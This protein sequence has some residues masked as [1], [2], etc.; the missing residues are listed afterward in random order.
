VVKISLAIIL[1]Q[2][3]TRR[4]RENYFA[5]NYLICRPYLHT[6]IHTYL[7]TTWSTVLLEKLTGLQLIKKFPRFYGTRMFNTA[8]TSAHYLSLSWVS[9]IQSITPN[10]NSLRSILILSSHLRL[11]LQS[12]FF[13]PGFPHQNPEC[14]SPIHHTSYMP[15]PSHSSRFRHPNTFVGLWRIHE[16]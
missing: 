8:L 10:H 1:K 3:M 15:R 16:L 9:S 14:A 11:G 5:S 4:K 13:P 6:Y 2:K 12:E 7:I